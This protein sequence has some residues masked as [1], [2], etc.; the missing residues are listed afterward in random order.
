MPWHLGEGMLLKSEI[1]LT[2]KASVRASS[3]VE[4]CL[5]TNICPFFQEPG[6]AVSGTYISQE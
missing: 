5:D 2:H 4:L 1:A 3:M 6:A